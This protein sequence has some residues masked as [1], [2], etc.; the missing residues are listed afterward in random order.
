VAFLPPPNLPTSIAKKFVIDVGRSPPNF[1][2]NHRN[3]FLTTSR[4]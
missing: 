3:T 2:I 1:T 4:R